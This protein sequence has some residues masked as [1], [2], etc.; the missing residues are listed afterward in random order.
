MPLISPINFTNKIEH[1][2]KKKAKNKGFII[3]QNTHS[4]I[5]TAATVACIPITKL[6]KKASLISKDESLELL[7]AANKGLKQ[8]GLADKNAEIFK[9]H[10]VPLEKGTIKKS[11]KNVFNLVKAVIKK[12]EKSIDKISS[13]FKNLTEKLLTYT[14]DDQKALG[15]INNEFKTALLKGAKDDGAF[16]IPQIL[17]NALAFPVKSGS[18]AFCLSKTN[19]IIIP[20]KSLQTTVFHEMGHALNANSGAITKGLQKCRGLSKQIPQL[21]LLISLLNKTKT[22]D[23]TDKS[24][25]IFKKGSNFIKRNAGKLAFI[26]S[27]PTVLEEGIASLRGQKVAKNLVKEGSLSKDLYKKVKISN[28][29]GFSTY[30]IAALAF[31]WGVKKAVEVKDKIQ[32]KNENV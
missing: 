3:A 11:V 7:N 22:T 26:T 6:A 14:K 28:L 31:G 21:I 5:T 27:L 17:I 30:L 8:T 10:E 24:D 2:K 12:D 20:D 16:E 25:S 23:E 19:K 18:N 32:E 15:A 1:H 9:I 29:A 4:L 13:D